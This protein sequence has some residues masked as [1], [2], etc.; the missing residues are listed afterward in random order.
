MIAPLRRGALP[1]F[2]LPLPSGG[3]VARIAPGG[4]WRA[5]RREVFPSPLRGEGGAPRA[6]GSPLSPWGEGG[7]HRAGRSSLSLRGGGW[8]A[9]RRR[10]AQFDALVSSWGPTRSGS[11]G[12]YSRCAPRRGEGST[13]ALRRP[14]RL[15]L[16][17]LHVLSRLRLRGLSSTGFAAASGGSK[18][19]VLGVGAVG[20]S[21]FPTVRLW[22]GARCRR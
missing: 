11:N 4:G 17:G 7:A 21:A 2:V 12:D 13:L 14:R 10:G 18:P 16:D 15:Q 5:S 20:A 19:L 6:G 22:P 9:S 1:V 3:R 8:R